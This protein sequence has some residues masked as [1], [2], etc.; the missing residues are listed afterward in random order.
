MPI[1]IDKPCDYP[2]LVELAIAPK[3]G[4]SVLQI[5]LRGS[6]ALKLFKELKAL[7]FHRMHGLEIFKSN[8]DRMR[9]HEIINKLIQGDVRKLDQYKDLDEKYDWIVW[10]HG[11]EHVTKKEFEQTLP[12]L[13]A[14]AR[15]GIWLGAP[16]GEWRQGAIHGNPNEKHVYHWTDKEWED[17]GFTVYTWSPL[18]G[19]KAMMG[20]KYIEDSNA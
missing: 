18:K 12:M 13:L 7:G 17:Y 15:I 3:G 19:R 1:A 2:N 11:P 14:K 5:G 6:G 8:A 4:K 16:N 9:R 10:H 20:V